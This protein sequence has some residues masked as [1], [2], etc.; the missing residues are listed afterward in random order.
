MKLREGLQRATFKSLLTSCI[1]LINIEYFYFEQI[2][3]AGVFCYVTFLSFCKS[4]L[5]LIIRIYA[6]RE[7]CPHSELF[8]SVFSPN[9]G[10]YGPDNSEYGHFLCSGSNCKTYM[11]AMIFLRRKVWI[12]TLIKLV[13]HTTNRDFFQNI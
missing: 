8:W 6:L 9:G 4:K 2:F 5:R 13:F 1:I 3:V 7:K 11:Y 12:E 10:K